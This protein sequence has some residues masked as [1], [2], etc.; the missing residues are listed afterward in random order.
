MQI[1]MQE[2]GNTGGISLF[3]YSFDD[4]P[5]RHFGHATGNIPGRPRDD[6]FD[7]DP[8]GSILQRASAGIDWKK[9]RQEPGVERHGNRDPQGPEPRREGQSDREAG[10]SGRQENRDA[11]SE[12]APT[13]PD[14]PSWPYTSKSVCQF[15]RCSVTLRNADT[16]IH[17]WH[18]TSRP[19]RRGV[20]SVAL[21]E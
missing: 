4:F 7:P 1:V 20:P 21:P 11:K 14:R 10:S 19:H 5:V 3:D 16:S 17:L 12:L 15:V 13:S 6:S 8:P 2:A 18:G 9:V